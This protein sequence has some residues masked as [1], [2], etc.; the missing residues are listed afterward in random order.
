M[1][2]TSA[3]TAYFYTTLDD[4]QGRVPSTGFH[5]DFLA[6]SFSKNGKRFTLVF[7]GT[8]NADALNLVDGSFTVKAGGGGGVSGN[9][10]GSGDGNGSGN[11]SDGSGTGCTTGTTSSSTTA[12]SSSS[13]SSGNLSMQGSA[14]TAETSTSNGTDTGASTDTGCTG[15]TGTSDGITTF[16]GGYY[17]STSGQTTGQQGPQSTGTGSASFSLDP[18][19]FRRDTDT[20]AGAP[21]K[22]VDCDTGGTRLLKPR[23]DN[24][25]GKRDLEGGASSGEVARK[26][27]ADAADAAPEIGCGKAADDPPDPAKARPTPLYGR[28]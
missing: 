24:G 26:G 23:A 13:G 11:G 14:G 22:E 1:V 6:N 16:G 5:Y 20:S 25:G 19:S 8:G 21:P 28:M 9:G 3:A 10:N 15:D 7:T 4:P 18:R 12:Q 17:G 2:T 27:S